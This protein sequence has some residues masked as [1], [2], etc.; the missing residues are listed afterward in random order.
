M[1]TPLLPLLSLAAVQTTLTTMRIGHYAPEIGASGGIAT[2]IRRIGRAQSDRGHSVSYLSLDAASASLPGPS[3]EV[4]DADA[5]FAA[6]DH[7]D[8]D[9]LHL[10]RAVDS[11]PDDRVPTIRTVHGHQGGCPSGT[12]YL[13]RSGEPCHRDYTVAGC[14]W[15]HF[16]DRCGSVRPHRL[17]RHFSRIHR[18]LDQAERLPTYTVSTFLRTQMKRAGCSSDTLDT[19]HSP[20]PTVQ[21]PFTPVPHTGPPTFLY[22]GRLAPEKG[23][24]WLLRAFAQVEVS[25]HLEV[26]GEGR[27]REAMETLAEDLGLTDTVTFHGWVES[28][29]V[30]SLIRNARAV[31]FPSVW[32]EPAGL[33]SLE[34]AAHGRPLIA[35]RVGGIPEYAD[36]SHATLVDVRD[37]EALAQA[38]MR[39]ATDADR[40]NRRGKNGRQV[41]R[42]EFSMSQFLDRLHTFYARVGAPA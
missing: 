9:L 5:L 8:L 15:G 38:I 16:V 19:I 2:Y 4:S 34:A 33:I 37:Q 30:P 24:D 7:R 41:V 14:L 18:E 27:E 25:A 35:S 26:A 40:A 28:E 17:K 13:S 22:L 3:L 21:Q 29:Q 12:R 10:H 6:A 36:E 32:H 42:S 1:H 11:L 23:L 39:L 20:A 31:I